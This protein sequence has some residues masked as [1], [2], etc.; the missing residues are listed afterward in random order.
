[1]V[2]GT[3]PPLSA[4]SFPV[5]WAPGQAYA[6]EVGGPVRI[7]NNLTVNLRGSTIP[8]TVGPLYEFGIGMLD[9]GTVITGDFVFG[10]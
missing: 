3:I 2:K 5:V 1:V 4:I 8:A 9:F 6:E 7:N 10:G